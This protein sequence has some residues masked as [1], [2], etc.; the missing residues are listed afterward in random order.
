MSTYGDLQTGIADDVARSDLTTQIQKEILAAIDDF[1][2]QR[3]AFNQTRNLTFVTVPN[4]AFYTVADSALIPYI[5]KVDRL[6]CGDQTSGVTEVYND[7][8]GDIERFNWF[9]SSR[10]SKFSFFANDG[11]RL[12]PTPVQ[13]WNMR[14]V[15]HYKLTPLSALSDSNDWTNVGY[16]L[17]RAAAKQRLYI[18]TIRDP[19]EATVLQAVVDAELTKLQRDYIKAENIGNRGNFIKATSF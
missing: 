8:T 16:E 11:L 14:G 1:S 2:Y 13:A 10:P 4:Q 19:D 15:I 12:W 18:N 6:L 5:I 9:T 17:I 7:D 3:F